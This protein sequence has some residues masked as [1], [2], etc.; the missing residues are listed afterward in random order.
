MAVLDAIPEM[1]RELKFFPA[2]TMHPRKLT[3]EQIRFF[4]EKGYIFPIHLFS[5]EEADAN[6]RYFNKLLK[7]ASDAGMDR[8]SVNG[9]Q[10]HCAGIYDLVT[11][12][13]IL[14]YVEDILG[15]NL[16]CR[17]THYFAKT[18]GDVKAVYWHQDA[19]F[20]YLT[21]SK[22]LTVWLAIDDVDVENGAMKLFPGTHLLGRIP[23]EWVTD[24]EDGV[25]NQHVHNPEQYAQPVSVELKAGQISLHT[26]MLLH[27]SQPNLSNRRRCGLTIRYFPPDVRGQDP[28]GLPAIIARGTD[29]DGYW[30]HIPRPKG[31][32]IPPHLLA[33]G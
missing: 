25:L 30:Q 19:S 12:E 8:Y 32:A 15:P 24:E 6:R 26:D 3:P 13:R 21:P 10:T 18:P 1:Q 23:F 7:M 9:W 14:D 28:T 22:V 2:Q 27:G 16:V 33:T 20:W 11:D 31:D 29:P 5:E 17:M 4:N